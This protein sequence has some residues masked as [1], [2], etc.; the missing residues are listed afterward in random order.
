MSDSKAKGQT[1]GGKEVERAADSVLGMFV[2]MLSTDAQNTGGALTVER[3]QFI[4][5]SLRTNRELLE[6]LYES[7]FQTCIRLF[8]DGILKEKRENCL[9]RILVQRFQH[10]ISEDGNLPP[11]SPEISR[12]CIPGFI[13]IVIKTIG[14]DHY[15]ASYAKARKILG[16]LK[17]KAGEDTVWNAFCK[18]EETQALVREVLLAL[19]A[20]F[21]DF[22]KRRTW[23]IDVMN[24]E[25]DHRHRL[26]SESGGPA[27][28]RFKKDHF[29]RLMQALYTDVPNLGA[30]LENVS[31]RAALATFLTYIDVTP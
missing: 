28:W 21:E 10:M 23:F 12:L 4:A 16:A 18:S 13:E 27:G 5:E 30:E 24:S 3:I 29:Q 7:A 22:E 26:E 31:E 15:D 11:D 25:I 1:V 19:M 14:Q 2:Q 9:G 17:E 20:Q 8:E 6:P